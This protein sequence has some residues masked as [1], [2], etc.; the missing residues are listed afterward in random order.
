ML[1]HLRTPCQHSSCLQQLFSS[2]QSSLPSY[3]EQRRQ[4]LLNNYCYLSVEVHIKVLSSNVKTLFTVLKS[5]QLHFMMPAKFIDLTYS[6]L[7][8]LL[9]KP[10]CYCD[11][12]DSSISGHWEC[13]ISLN[14]SLDDNCGRSE[15]SCIWKLHIFIWSLPSKN[16]S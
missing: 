14:T 5:K 3:I 6:F 2:P 9:S 8:D 4:I 11:R 7:C 10:E 13:F 15:T 12:S 1:W 16:L